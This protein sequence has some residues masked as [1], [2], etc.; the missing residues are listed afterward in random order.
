MP[1]DHFAEGGLANAYAQLDTADAAEKSLQSFRRARSLAENTLES[2]PDD[3]L[4]TISLA[5]Y[6][7]VLNDADCAASNQARAW[8]LAPD[9]VDVNYM[10]ALVHAQLG[11]MQ[12]A[13]AATQRALDLG[14]PQALLVTDPQL[15][16]VW[17]QRRFATAG[18]TAMFDPQR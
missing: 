15:A 3:A 10:S 12:A 16:P 18:L 13:S 2:D 5:Y 4:T 7:A 1:A 6:C 9:S 17:S 11:D 8:Q 14:Y